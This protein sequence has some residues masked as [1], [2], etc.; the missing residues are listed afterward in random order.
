MANPLQKR[1]FYLAILILAA[2]L[3]IFN[4]SC[5]STRYYNRY[6]KGKVCKMEDNGVKKVRKNK[7]KG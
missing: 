2:S 4:S 1:T 3:L 5:S 6:P 7:T